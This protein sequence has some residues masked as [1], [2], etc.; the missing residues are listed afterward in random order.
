MA[1]IEDCYT[2]AR[3]HTRTGGNFVKATFYALRKSYAFLSPDLWAPT[4]FMKSPM[5][6]HSDFLGGKATAKKAY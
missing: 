4:H 2:S 5:Q 6:E 1:G 3:G